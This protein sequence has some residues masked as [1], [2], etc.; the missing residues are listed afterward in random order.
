MTHQIRGS[1]FSHIEISVIYI[2]MN[3]ATQ[4]HIID[5][6]LCLKY[7]ELA[8]DLLSNYLNQNGPSLPVLKL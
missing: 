6:Q 1:V 5:N 2:F 4:Q 3:I 8:T 7:D